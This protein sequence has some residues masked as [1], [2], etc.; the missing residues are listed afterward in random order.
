LAAT[1]PAS[2]LQVGASRPPCNAA[3]SYDCPAGRGAFD[4]GAHTRSWLL[5]A[6]RPRANSL[7]HAY[8]HVYGAGA[9]DAA[10]VL[11]RADRIRC[12]PS[13]HDTASSLPAT[14]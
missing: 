14:F 5:P 3:A 10:M 12:G 2:P 4:L 11:P 8:R 6:R 9:H 7:R 1:M 13:T